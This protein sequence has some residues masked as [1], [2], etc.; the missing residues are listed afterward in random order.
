M[1]FDKIIRLT[2]AMR[3]PGD[4]QAAFRTALSY[5]REPSSITEMD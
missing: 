2:I 1:A 4:S 3:Q 5:F